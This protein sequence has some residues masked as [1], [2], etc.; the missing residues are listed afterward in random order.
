MAEVLR[1]VQAM[2]GIGTEQLRAT[3]AGRTV[4]SLSKELKGQPFMQDAV[5]AVR[6]VHVGC[7]LQE[8]CA[9]SAPVSAIHRQG[10]I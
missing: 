4:T 2:D 7:A 10:A 1:E 6:S 3:G 5:I 8:S 9:M